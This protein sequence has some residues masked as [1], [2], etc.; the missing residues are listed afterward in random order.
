[1]H[2]GTHLINEGLE[3]GE[4]IENTSTSIN[5]LGICYVIAFGRD[6]TE[7]SGSGA[8]T[9]LYNGCFVNRNCFRIMVLYWKYE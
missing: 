6:P 7:V 8:S 2:L 1:M 9:S 3:T 5:G 4:Y